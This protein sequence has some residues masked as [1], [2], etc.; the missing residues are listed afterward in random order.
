MPLKSEPRYPQ[1]QRSLEPGPTRP[2][3]WVH[4]RLF[5]VRFPQTPHTY[6]SAQG[7]RW[8][9]VSTRTTLS[10][11]DF[12]RAQVSR[13]TK[14]LI[15]G[16]QR[17]QRLAPHT[18]Q[19]GWPC[20][21]AAVLQLHRKAQV[22]VGKVWKQ[23]DT[24]ESCQR[25]SPHVGLGAGESTLTTGTSQRHGGQRHPRPPR[26]QEGLIASLVYRLEN[27]LGSTSGVQPP[28]ALGCCSLQEIEILQ[29]QNKALITIVAISLSC[30]SSSE[31]A[32]GQ[33]ETNTSAHQSLR[34]TQDARG[35]A[36]LL[37]GRRDDRFLI[38]AHRAAQPAEGY[39]PSAPLLTAFQGK[40]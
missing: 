9:R 33:P 24:A 31:G 26:A 7:G 13:P 29:V 14:P 20:T 30:S 21:E 10:L 37:L 22:A 12:S 32:R 27:S 6:C 4:Q 5:K 23:L 11:S 2:S 28:A 17:D 25:Q 15:P 38:A 39:L 19:R 35:A 16:S 18:E 8:G 34:G 3:F 36:R 1:S 40:G